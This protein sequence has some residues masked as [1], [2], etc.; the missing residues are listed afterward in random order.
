MEIVNA[1]KG[2]HEGRYRCVVKNPAGSI[3]ASADLKVNKS[4]CL[5]YILF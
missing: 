1:K 3:S 5:F 4:E 2:E